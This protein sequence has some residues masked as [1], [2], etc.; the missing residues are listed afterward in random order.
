MYTFRHKEWKGESEREREA[1][2]KKESETEIK[3]YKMHTYYEPHLVDIVFDIIVL[4]WLRSHLGC[5][6]SFIRFRV[7]ACASVVQ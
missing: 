2:K 5:D 7:C 4:K 6:V 1:E 3:V